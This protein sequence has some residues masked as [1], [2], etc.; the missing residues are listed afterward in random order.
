MEDGIP[1]FK[2]FTIYPGAMISDSDILKIMEAAKPEGALWGFYAES[3]VIAEFVTEKL[4]EYFNKATSPVW[5][6]G[7]DER[8]LCADRPAKGIIQC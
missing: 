7:S 5:Y 1:G 2:M 6:A 8:G 3:N 4:W